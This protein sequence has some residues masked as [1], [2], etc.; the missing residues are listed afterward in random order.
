MLSLI[1]LKE[2]FVL[3]DKDGD[4]RIT[5]NELESVMKSM[6]ETPTPKELRQII[7]D[8]DTDGNNNFYTWM[9]A[10]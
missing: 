3:F 10:F 1:E 6:G 7:H 8:V 4:G 2:A 9:H 5:A